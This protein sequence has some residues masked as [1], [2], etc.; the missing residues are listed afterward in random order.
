[1]NVEC[2]LLNLQSVYIWYYEYYIGAQCLISL[3]C[4][5]FNL[6]LGQKL[7][8]LSNRLSKSDTKTSS[9]GRHS[10]HQP[11]Q[12]LYFRKKAQF[13][14]ISFLCTSVIADNFSPLI[15]KAKYLAYLTKFCKKLRGK[16]ASICS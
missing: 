14:S 7:Q 1:M 2:L 13:C 10:L 12:I 16:I 9:N 3:K 4:L 11:S 8:N 15:R 5:L 6:L